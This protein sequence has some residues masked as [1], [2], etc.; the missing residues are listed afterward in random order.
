MTGAGIS[1][2]RPRCTRSKFVESNSNYLPAHSKPLV[3]LGS[4]DISTRVGDKGSPAAK[5]TTMATPKSLADKELM[6]YP[7][8]VKRTSFTAFAV[9]FPIVLIRFSV[10]SMQIIQ[11]MR[12]RTFRLVLEHVFFAK[13]RRRANPLPPF[14]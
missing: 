4:R 11:I 10:L 9:L 1:I 12:K 13:L 14:P 7:G 8:R 2:S 6:R 3:A 5:R